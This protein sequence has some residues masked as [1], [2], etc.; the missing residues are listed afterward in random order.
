M[1][2]CRILLFPVR[3]YQGGVVYDGV[4]GEDGLR[5]FFHLES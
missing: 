4:L 1:G 2:F 5:G 3:E